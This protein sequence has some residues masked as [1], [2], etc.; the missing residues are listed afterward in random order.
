MECQGL[1]LKSALTVSGLGLLAWYILFSS[2]KDEQARVPSKMGVPAAPKPPPTVVASAQSAPGPKLTPIPSGQS[3]LLV[4]DV[5]ALVA[6][7]SMRMS[8]IESSKSAVAP[9]MAPQQG[10]GAVRIFSPG[11]EIIASGM[12]LAD[13]AFYAAETSKNSDG[14]EVITG[15][16]RYTVGSPALLQAAVDGK[17]FKPDFDPYTGQAFT[18]RGEG[19]KKALMAKKASEMVSG[20]LGEDFR[21][22]PMS[23][24]RYV[25][26]GRKLPPA[27]QRRMR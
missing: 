19:I 16:K 12:D 24:H 9:Y 4:R 7:Q 17:P 26:V 13:G 10:A 3:M 20:S 15:F 25:I 18:P 22:E 6:P 27:I 2:K 1:T 8:G 23:G 11:E 14:Q 21:D 5:R